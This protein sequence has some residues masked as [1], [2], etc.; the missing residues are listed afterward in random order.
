MTNQSGLGVVE[1]GSA[2]KRCNDNEL[3]GPRETFIQIVRNKSTEEF[4]SFPYIATLLSASIWTYYGIIKPGAML[5]ST[6]NGFGAVAQLLYVI[7]F[8]TFAPPSKRATTA[9]LVGIV[10]V[11]CLGAIILSSWFMLNSDTRIKAIGFIG[12]GLNIVMYGSPL[13][14]LGTV[15]K[16]RS[17]EY[18][19]LPL[20]LCVFLNGGIWTFYALLA[21][22]PFLGVPNAVGFI[23]GAIQLMV[24]VKY[25]TPSTN[26]QYHEH[27]IGSSIP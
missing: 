16:N 8:L 25:R 17:V 21:N 2:S 15:M 20:S 11:G 24:Y 5:V 1:F 13:A 14:A 18:M 3:R 22:D 7:L 10:D 9:M 26:K 6:V 12:A 27:L 23:L 4:E 19:P